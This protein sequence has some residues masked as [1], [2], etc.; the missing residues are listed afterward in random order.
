MF[1]MFY[2]PRKNQYKSDQIKF[3]PYTSLFK[4]ILYAQISKHLDLAIIFGTRGI[5]KIHLSPGS[6]LYV[7]H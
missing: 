1:G 4:S 2:C 6:A 5:Y 3:I 7:R